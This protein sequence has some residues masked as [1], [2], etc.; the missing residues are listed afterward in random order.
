MSHPLYMAQACTSKRARG[1]LRITTPRYPTTCHILERRWWQNAP[2]KSDDN[3]HPE[4]S[5]PFQSSR[6]TVT[7]S[8]RSRPESAPNDTGSTP[9]GIVNTPNVIGSTPNASG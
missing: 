3:P 7:P 6:G 4:P 8:S 2:T 5:I 9:N 1:D